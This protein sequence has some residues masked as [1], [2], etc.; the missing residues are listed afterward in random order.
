MLG[1][2]MSPERWR[3][4]E[5]LYHAAL[6]RQESQRAAYLRETS[7]GDDAMQW[8]APEQLRG[9]KVDGRTCGR[10]GRCCMRRRPAANRFRKLSVQ[11]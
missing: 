11:G 5:Q 10:W 4:I 7:A 6:E 8:E 1:N 2:S 3:K 9:E